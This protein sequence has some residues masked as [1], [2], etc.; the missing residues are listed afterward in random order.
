MPV[1]VEFDVQGLEQKFC[2]VLGSAPCGWGSVQD[3]SPPRF[4]AN[5]SLAQACSRLLG[6]GSG[7][8]QGLDVPLAEVGAG[9]LQEVMAKPSP[10]TRAKV[11]DTRVNRV[12]LRRRSVQRC[13]TF[14]I[15]L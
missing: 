5:N 2:R 9:C 12:K 3:P 6:R 8:A 4:G 13:Q 11:G 1:D 10:K 14:T 7:F 15:Q